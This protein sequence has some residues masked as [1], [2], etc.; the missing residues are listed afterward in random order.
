MNWFYSRWPAAA[1]SMG[2]VLLLLAP[3]WSLALLVIY[4]QLPIY[5]LHQLEE[6]VDHRFRTLVHQRIFGGAEPLTPMAILVINLPGVWG[7]SLA[8]L[9]AAIFVGVG[10]GLTAVYL[11]VLN[12]V[13]HV[14]AA[15]A[16]RACNP[17]LWTSIALFLPVGGLALRVVS[18]APGVM[19]VHH[20]VG[21]AIA[22]AI[23]IAI[24]VYARVRTGRLQTAR[25]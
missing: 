16:S 6:H 8:C 10:W 2:I 15:V 20:T 24:V 19:A 21:I 23:H 17:G 1:L 25:A 12:G 9:Y 3:T 22:L 13:T 18:A 4:L 5:L 14:V 11:V 7:L